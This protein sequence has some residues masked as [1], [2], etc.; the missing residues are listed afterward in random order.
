M[1]LILPRFTSYPPT[2]YMG[3]KQSILTEIWDTLKDLPFNTALDAF[4]GS[5][6]VGYMFKS[7]GKTVIANDFLKYAY[8]LANALVAN[9]CDTLSDEDV[10]QLIATNPERGDFV[11]TTY[12]DLYFSDPDNLFLD[13]TLANLPKLA[14]PYKRSL[15]LAALSRACIKRRPRGVFTYVGDRYD[16]GRRD[17]KLTLQEQFVEAVNLLNAA[18]FDNGQ[19]NIALNQDVF[20]LDVTP[21]LAYFDPPYYTQRSDNDYLRRYH[22]VEGLCCNWQGVE[23]LHDTKTKKLRKYPTPFDSR[24]QVREAFRRLFEKFSKSIIVVSYSSNGLPDRDDLYQML[25]AIKGKVEVREIDYRY[26]FGTHSHKI[27]NQ[28]NLV[29]EYLFIAY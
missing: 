26:S 14:S 20:T 25:Q 28:N 29:Q 10:A 9:N 2:R 5:G 6:C 16:D 11:Q 23:I 21:D 17:L 19:P 8:Q 15:A 1:Q 18:V 7:Q 22:F 13:N 3:S 24:I 4:S 12:K 27:G